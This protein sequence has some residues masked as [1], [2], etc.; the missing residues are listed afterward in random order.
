M[1][2]T[3]QPPR[4][5]VMQHFT[6]YCWKTRKYNAGALVQWLWEETHV[7]KVVGSNLS[8]LYWMDISSHL[9]VGKIVTFG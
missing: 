3:R 5:L 6:T 2:T 1:M 4:A 8:T 9:F 7:P